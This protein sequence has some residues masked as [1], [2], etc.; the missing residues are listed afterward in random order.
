MRTALY[1]AMHSL[2]S[3]GD[4][5]FILS[6]AGM[7]SYTGFS[8]EEV[9]HLKEVWHVY[10]L[11]TGRVNIAGCMNST[12]K[13]VLTEVNLENVNYVAKAFDDVA[14]SRST[15]CNGL[16]NVDGQWAKGALVPL[17]HIVEI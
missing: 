17:G 2:R 8:A 12:W 4:W 5:S 16:I 13:A 3:P 6:Q 1:N 15:H 7:F 10:L 14:W 11:D 9:R